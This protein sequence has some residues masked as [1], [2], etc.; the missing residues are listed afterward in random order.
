MSVRLHIG[1]HKTATTHL[2]D[3]LARNRQNLAESGVFFIPREELRSSG[4]YPPG[5]WLRRNLNWIGKG[6][7]KAMQQ[8]NQ[9][10]LHTVAISEELLAGLAPDMLESPLYPHAEQRLRSLKALP[11]ARFNLS[12]FLS[13]RSFDEA[14]PSA[15]AQAL[16]ARPIPGGMSPLIESLWRNPPSWTSYVKRLARR[17]PEIPITVWTI[18]RYLADPEAIAEVFVGIPV[19]DLKSEAPASTRTPSSAAIAQ[20][21][22]LGSRWS[23]KQTEAEWKAKVAGI[24]NQQIKGAEKFNPLPQELR[25]K[26]RDVFEND[27]RLIA[28]MEPQV[29]LID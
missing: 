27:R 16:R 24:F 25:E 26:L 22:E 2:Q 11:P 17:F 28:N 4:N 15:Y 14:F 7:E 8:P 3:G 10:S 29:K 9:R 23:H 18:D 1:A 13:I 5:R 21:E 6:L 19:S 12:L 20:V